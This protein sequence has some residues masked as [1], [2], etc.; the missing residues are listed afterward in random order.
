MRRNPRK[1][2]RDE[3]RAELIELCRRGV[4]TCT[5]GNPGDDDATYALGWLPLDNPERYADAVREQ[6]ARNMRALGVA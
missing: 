2:Q 3:Y 6:H 1:R 4:I 5:R